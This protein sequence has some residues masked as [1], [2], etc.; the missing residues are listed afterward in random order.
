MNDKDKAAVA[1]AKNA[2]DNVQSN[3]AVNETEKFN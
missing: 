3:N 1:S 2:K